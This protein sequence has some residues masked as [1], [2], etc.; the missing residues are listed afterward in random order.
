[1]I[2]EKFFREF[3]YLK[4]TA[5]LDVAS[6]GLQ[7]ERTL[8]HC[9]EF[10]QKFV[11]SRGRICFG[12]YG[13]ERDRTAKL[14]AQ[15]VGADVPGQAETGEILFTTNT[16]E[17]NSLL[18]GCYPL[19]AGDSVISGTGEYPSVV[20][21]WAM[22]RKEGVRLKLVPERNGVLDADEI[23]ARMDETTR[24]VSLSFVQYLSG[25]QADLQKIGRECRK[26]NILFMVDGI[27]GVGR[28]PV[29][30]K[31]MCIDVLSCGA[32]KGLFGPFGTGFVYIRKELIPRLVPRYFSENNIEVDEDAMHLMEEFPEFAWRD[33]IQR[34]EGGSKNT[35]GITAMGKN[36]ELLLEIGVENIQEHIRTL[37]REFRDRVKKE[38][39]PVS[40]LGAEEERYW[41]GNICM[42]FDREKT[43]KLEKAL[44]EKDIY[45]KLDPGFLRL[46]L[47]YYN[48]PEQL[49][50]TAGVLREV[51]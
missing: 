42:N 10:Q 15:I 49:R 45:A 32:F 16:T 18:A 31:E 13:E 34:L 36:I 30:V 3:A 50:R 43:G 39:L 17:G 44:K 27:Q 11:D 9:R 29:N 35:Y 24:V 40:F 19:K 46:G 47:H 38:N 26:R 7:P 14:A 1:M 37:E 51:L 23:I 4:D 20:L 2:E 48:T 25:F 6:V 41:S 33:G 5:Y 22:K 28:N 8:K 21:G 12:P